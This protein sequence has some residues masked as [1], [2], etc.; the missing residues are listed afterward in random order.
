[1]S[2]PEETTV[3]TEEKPIEE[4]TTGTNTV[5]ISLGNIKKSSLPKKLS[6]E[7]STPAPTDA[8][9]PITP[10]IHAPS[11]IQLSAIKSQKK[12]EKKQETPVVTKAQAEQEDTEEKVSDT[13]TKADLRLDV[14]IEEKKE[15]KLSREEIQKKY[16]HNLPQIIKPAEGE[17]FSQYTSEFIEKE[18]HI[19]EKIRKLK[20][21]PRTRPLFVSSLVLVTIAGIGLLFYIDPGT[22]SL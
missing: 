19:M 16:A 15:T 22:H 18:P 17:I 9:T 7:T 6:G 20:E 8:S 1:M 5:R 13:L 3:I 4:E 11:K 2:T 21:M 10:K 12:P 14:E